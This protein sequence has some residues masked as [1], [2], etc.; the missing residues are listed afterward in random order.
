MCFFA[1]W[2]LSLIAVPGGEI[3]DGAR[4]LPGRARDLGAPG[5]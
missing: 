1:A 5:R 4:F 3:V 2:A